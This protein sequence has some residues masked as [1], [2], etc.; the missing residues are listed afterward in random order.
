MAVTVFSATLT[1]TPAAVVSR[2]HIAGTGIFPTGVH[3]DFLNSP[4]FMNFKQ[5]NELTFAVGIMMMLEVEY[6]AVPLKP[7]QFATIVEGLSTWDCTMLMEVM[8]VCRG[9]N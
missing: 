7:I 5:F 6:I 4:K 2:A 9:K 8:K 3:W 1:W